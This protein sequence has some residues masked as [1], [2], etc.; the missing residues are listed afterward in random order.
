ML[1]RLLLAAVAVFFL[2]QAS[3]ADEI[4]SMDF[5][6][7]VDGSFNGGAAAN[8]SGTFVTSGNVAITSEALV[9]TADGGSDRII[10]QSNADAVA[11]NFTFDVSHANFDTGTTDIFFMQM[12]DGLDRSTGGV[13]VSN[14]SDTVDAGNLGFSPGPATINYFFNTSAASIDYTAPDS[15]TQT[16]AAGS[17]SLWTN[18]TL[19]V[20]NQTQS[21]NGAGVPTNVDSLVLQTFGG[22][23]GSTFTFDN[24]SFNTFTAVPEPSSLVLLGGG[25]LLGLFYRRRYV[26]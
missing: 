11:G 23:S 13:L 10:I 12:V 8:G 4:W 7:V 24:L 25:C 3:P 18:T 2:A 6:S 22:Q 20:A 5:G 15:T 16:L 19:S 26:A 9:L 17:Y 14:F 1:N 21:N